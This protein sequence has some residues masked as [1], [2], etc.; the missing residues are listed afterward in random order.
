MSIMPGKAVAIMVLSSSGKS[1]STK[2]LLGFYMPVDGQIKIDGDDICYPSG[3]E[4]HHYFGVAP[5]ETVLFSGTI[6][7]NLSIANPN[8]TFE[9]TVHACQLAKIHDVIKA[10]HLVIRLRSANVA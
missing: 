2:F 6:Y 7:E 5:Q 8:A 9:Q 3:N 4:L 1:T 10:Y